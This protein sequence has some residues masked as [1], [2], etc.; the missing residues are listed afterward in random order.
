MN[1]LWTMGVLLAA[2][3][4]SAAVPPVIPFQGRIT[5]TDG[6]GPLNGAHTVIF[7]LY[8]TAVGATADVVYAE[9]QNVAFT[10][11]AFSV[12]IGAMSPLMTS[13]FQNN[14]E[15]HLG[16]H[17]GGD[18]NELR[19]LFRIGTAP[20]AMHAASADSAATVAGLDA[21]SLARAAQLASVSCPHGSAVVESDA[22]VRCA[23][24]KDA[25]TKTEADGR[26]AR[27]TACYWNWVGGGLDAGTIVTAQCE[28]GFY[29]MAGGCDINASGGSI[30]ESNP[31]PSSGNYKAN[32]SPWPVGATATDPVNPV[33]DQWRCRVTPG[34]II[35]VA[36]VLCCP[37][38]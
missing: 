20:Y 17:I 12:S 18:P 26:F 32:T 37:P 29:A 4:A 21:G 31:G 36:F 24:V 16:V 30:V 3:V 33:I 28:P 10:D 27:T 1:R 15:L 11:G 34:G 35:D 19:P 23:E 25:Y 5:A 8:R 9:T 6:S 2:S 22:G 13:I 38:R 14:S 7:T